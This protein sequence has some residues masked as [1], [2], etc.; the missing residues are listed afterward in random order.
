MQI[1]D[2]EIKKILG[3]RN[4]V[5]AI[6]EI[7]DHRLKTDDQELIE[8]VSRQVIQMP[9]RTD[10]IEELKAKIASGTYNVSGEDIAESMIKRSIADRID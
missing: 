10:R 4:I 8:N 2:N 5:A 6:V 7:D 3:S 1:S 9:D